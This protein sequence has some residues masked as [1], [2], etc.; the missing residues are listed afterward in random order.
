MCFSNT[1]GGLQSTL[2]LL[3]R[4]ILLKIL[5]SQNPGIIIQVKD[6]DEVD[7][8]EILLE[9]GISYFSIGHPVNERS[10]IVVNDT[11]MFTFDIDHLR[12]KW[13]QYFIP[14]RSQAVRTEACSG[15]I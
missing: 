14:S 4:V 10:L 15:K 8:A 7:V 13:F 9:N 6:E 2:L 3:M 5:F 12:D 1:S 11:D